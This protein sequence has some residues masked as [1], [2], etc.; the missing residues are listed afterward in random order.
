L[1]WYHL[2]L[3]WAR[4]ILKKLK[5]QID[6]KNLKKKKFILASFLVEPGQGKPK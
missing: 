4:G 3:N 6:K 2:C 1:L 5:K